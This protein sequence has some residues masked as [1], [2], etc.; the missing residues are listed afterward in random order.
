MVA[1]RFF[2]SGHCLGHVQPSD[3]NHTI[4]ERLQGFRDKRKFEVGTFLQR[5][6]IPGRGAMWMPYADKASHGGCCRFAQRRLSGQHR[7]EQRQSHGDANPADKP[8]PRPKAYVIIF[9]VNMRTNWG[10][11][12][13]SACLNSTGPLTF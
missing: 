4:T 11:Y 1:A 8:T 2:L 9:S 5:T 12:R 6:P 3:E 7:L 10:E 13:K